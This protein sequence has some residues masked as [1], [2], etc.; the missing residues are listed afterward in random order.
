MGTLTGASSCVLIS[1]VRIVGWLVSGPVFHFSDTWL[2]FINTATTVATFL[3][4]FLIQSSQDRATHALLDLEQL[5]DDES[6]QLR[7]HSVAL[8]EQARAQVRRGARDTGRP[9]VPLT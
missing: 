3:M 6:H 8:A 9:E 7:E 4:V 2:L 1:L 5:T